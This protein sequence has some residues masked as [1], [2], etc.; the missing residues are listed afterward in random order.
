METLVHVDDALAFLVQYVKSGHRDNP[1]YGYELELSNIVTSYLKETENWPPTIQYAHD[2]PRNREVSAAFFEAAWELCRRDV[3]RPSVRFLGGQ[4][5]ADGS[6]Y[7]IT[8]TGRLWIEKQTDEIL[9]GGPDRISQ[10]FEKFASQF[11]SAFLQR[12][13]EAAHCHAFGNYLACCAMCGAA[14]ESILLAVAIAKEGDETRVLTSYQAA[15][16]RHKLIKRIIGQA[17][18]GVAEPFRSATGL[19]SYWRDD[20]AHGLASSISEVEAHDALARLLRFA[21]FSTDQWD[22]AIGP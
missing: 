21:Q 18:P 15:G 3:L 10:L 19:L 22:E 2:H 5:R 16:G 12:A 17:R 8:A 1:G 11:G 14:T 4:G 9:I 13:A 7:T 6:G 20:A